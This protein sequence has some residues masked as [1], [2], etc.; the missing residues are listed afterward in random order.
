MYGRHIKVALSHPFLQDSALG[1]E[2]EL[3]NVLASE[4][5]VP[6][7]PLARKWGAGTP[8]LTQHLP[9]WAKGTSRWVG[10]QRRNGTML[11]SPGM[12]P[13]LGHGGSFVCF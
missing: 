3:W 5:L 12:Q 11:V 13:S 10:A 2:T 7:T 8:D 6:P 4:D 1:L 9:H